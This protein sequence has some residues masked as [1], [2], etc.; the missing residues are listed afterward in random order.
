MC[1]WPI[2]WYTSVLNYENPPSA[3]L[4]LS[5]RSI[6]SLRDSHVPARAYYLC[7]DYRTE[8]MM[9]SCSFNT[10]AWSRLALCKMYLTWIRIVPPLGPKLNLVRK[11]DLLWELMSEWSNFLMMSL[12]WVWEKRLSSRS[13]NQKICI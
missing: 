10:E 6:W 2:G 11:R 5:R 7:E 13:I 9:I 12:L 4:N 8:S 1:Y 3:R